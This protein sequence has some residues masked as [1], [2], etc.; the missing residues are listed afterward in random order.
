MLKR[1][2]IGLV[3]AGSLTICHIANA[4]TLNEVVDSIAV[5]DAELKADIAELN[6][7]LIS[8]IWCNED[9]TPQEIF[10]GLGSNAS[11]RIGLYIGMHNL[12]IDSEGGAYNEPMPPNE[13]TIN[14]DGF[15]TVG[16]EI[17]SGYSCGVN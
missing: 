10:D 9:F 17:E 13:I 2:I 16:D 14:F 5:K 4:Q 12:L 8:E 11:R 6:K 7:S 15:V 3:I 1:L